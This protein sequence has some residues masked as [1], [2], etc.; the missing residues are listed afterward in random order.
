MYYS[1]FVTED[2]G[3]NRPLC[4]YYMFRALTG[5][6]RF[7]FRGS[8]EID[9]LYAAGLA[10]EKAFW[11]YVKQRSTPTIPTAFFDPV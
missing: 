5:E 2:D 4:Q 9:P 1:D 7:G 10:E 3:V 8:I 11:E 6:M